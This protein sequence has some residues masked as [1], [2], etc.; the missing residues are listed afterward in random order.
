MCSRD[1]GRPKA[2][3]RPEGHFTSRCQI[4]LDN[5]YGWFARA[6]RGVYA[7]TDVGR[8]ALQR[9]PQAVGL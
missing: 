2:P 1:G 4:L 9:W 5:V 7:L 6:E 8:A 3:A